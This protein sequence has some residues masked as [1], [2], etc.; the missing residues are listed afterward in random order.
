M[1]VWDSGIRTTVNKYIE[2]FAAKLK[3]KAIPDLENQEKGLPPLPPYTKDLPA[4]PVVCEM[5]TADAPDSM[6]LTDTMEFKD[7]VST[8]EGEADVTV[9]I[10]YSVRTG[11][12]ILVGFVAITITIMTV[13][14]LLPDPPEL[15]KF[16]ASIWLAGTIICG[17]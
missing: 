5:E 14:V 1:M 6:E 12:I 17:N 16:F 2:K 3:K 7:K 13:R 11:I 4:I 10:P 9:M 15:Y 8:T